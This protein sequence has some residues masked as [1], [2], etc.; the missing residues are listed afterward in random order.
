MKT[1]QYKRNM[2]YRMCCVIKT[3]VHNNR[4]VNG[5]CVESEKQS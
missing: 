3:H 1:T 2:L 5:I 4:Q